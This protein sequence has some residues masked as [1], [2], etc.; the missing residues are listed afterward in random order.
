MFQKTQREDQKENFIVLYERSFEGMKGESI[1]KEELLSELQKSDRE[2]RE[3]HMY[4]TSLCCSWAVIC[5]QPF[6]WGNLQL[7]TQSGV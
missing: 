6:L 3:T 1:S 7:G 4:T 2:K 5:F